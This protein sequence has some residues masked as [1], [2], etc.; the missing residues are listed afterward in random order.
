MDGD[1]NADGGMWYRIV[2]PIGFRIH[3]L[4]LRCIIDLNFLDDLCDVIMER[5]G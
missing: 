2:F 1:R 5:E 4:V 3:T